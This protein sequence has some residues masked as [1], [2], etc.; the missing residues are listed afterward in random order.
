MASLI[1]KERLPGPQAVSD[2]QLLDHVKNHGGTAWHPVG[3]CRMGSDPQSVVDPTLRV[4]G[5]EGLRVV[6]ASIMP[7]IPSGNTSAPA[8]MIGEKGADLI[9]HAS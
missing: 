4:R 1:V 3:T 8:V 5:V 7:K 9:R 2:E 6:D